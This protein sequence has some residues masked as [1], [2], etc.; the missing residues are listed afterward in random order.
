MSF[1][2]MAH[3]LSKGDSDLS[4]VANGMFLDA[5]PGRSS[6]V[7]LCQCAKLQHVQT[8]T[9][10]MTLILIVSAC[11]KVCV[12]PCV[13]ACVSAS[14]HVSVGLSTHVSLG[15]SGHVSEHHCMCQC[16]CQRMCH[17]QHMLHDYS[18][19]L[20]KCRESLGLHAGAGNFAAFCI[21]P[22]KAGLGPRA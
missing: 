20:T 15:V 11:D 16:M 7:G 18:Y 13:N 3:A 14:L 19:A 6:E 17:I 2:P 5:E 22:S 12:K 21:L 8:H 1:S 10:D 4:A 9:L